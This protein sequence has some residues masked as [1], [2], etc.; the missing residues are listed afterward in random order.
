MSLGQPGM[1][2]PPGLGVWLV[3]SLIETMTS[4]MT[5]SHAAKESDNK[6]FD[7]FLSV[8]ISHKH[9]TLSMP[10]LL[11]TQSNGSDWMWRQ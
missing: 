8:L 6:I 1:T 9:A 7:S 4:S 2:L 5:A 11:P 3:A 10:Q